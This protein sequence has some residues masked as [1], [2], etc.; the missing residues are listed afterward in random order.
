MSEKLSWS[1][2]IISKI[3][4]KLISQILIGN[5]FCRRL[6]R[7]WPI[8]NDKSDPFMNKP[9]Y[10]LIKPTRAVLAHCYVIK[11]TQE[12]LDSF[13][14]GKNKEG[15]YFTFMLHASTLDSTTAEQKE[16]FNLIEQNE[17]S[18]WYFW[19][20]LLSLYFALIAFGGSF[21]QKQW[22]N[23]VFS[24]ISLNPKL[25]M[26]FNELDFCAKKIIQTRL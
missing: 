12:L 25:A 19:W 9:Y 13:Q 11:T 14:F 15:C 8:R 17:R 3:K 18:F 2:K 23:K 10:C 1:P 5:F 22:E 24:E 7:N 6:L 20:F 4:W 21:T 26:K 16:G